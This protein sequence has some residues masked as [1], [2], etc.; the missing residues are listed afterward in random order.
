MNAG[1]GVLANLRDE[2][3]RVGYR[4]A[5]QRSFYSVAYQHCHLRRIEFIHLRREFLAPFDNFRFASYASRFATESDLLEMKREGKWKISEELLKN[6]RD[7]QKCLLSY[8][9]DTLAG[10]T[11]VNDTGRAEIL[12]GL[13]ITIPHEYVY[14]FAGFTLPEFRG[15]KLQSY[16]HHEAL[17]R[18]EWR[19]R[20]G[21]LGYVESSN[22]SSKRG[23][24]KTGY[25]TLHQMT[26]VG[27]EGRLAAHVP[28]SLKAL[29]IRRVRD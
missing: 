7:G 11:W 15:F 25:R 23:Q 4:R 29:G 16:R 18:P 27:N 26:L 1:A 6:H 9:G 2:A 5:L 3:T 12:P 19:A 22:W 24:A 14:N 13:R 8:V 28:Q 10:Y 17:G 20:V 21:M